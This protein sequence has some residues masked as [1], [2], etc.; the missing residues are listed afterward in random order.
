MPLTANATVLFFNAA[1]DT[2]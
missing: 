1:L 2:A